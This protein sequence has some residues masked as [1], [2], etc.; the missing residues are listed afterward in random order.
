MLSR[1]LVRFEDVGSKQKWH[2]TSRRSRSTKESKSDQ[3]L[4]TENAFEALADEDENDKKEEEHTFMKVADSGIV[5]RPLAD[6]SIKENI[7]SHNMKEGNK[8]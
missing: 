3:I 2:P 5:S 8:D 6:K 7:I 4:N 1:D